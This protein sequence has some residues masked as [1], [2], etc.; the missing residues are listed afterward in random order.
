MLKSL[1]TI[2][3]IN[4]NNL[5][6]EG[7][8]LGALRKELF[9]LNTSKDDLIYKLNNE[10]KII[11]DETLIYLNQFILQMRKDIKMLGDLIILKAEEV[12]VQEDI[13]REMFTE[14][15]KIEILEHK[16]IEDI[17]TL[18]REKDRKELDEISQI[19]WKNNSKPRR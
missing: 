10:A 17:K 9:I 3:K 8:K 5:E 15:K 11:G 12:R 16:K 19:I 1:Q 13:V 14:L 7:Y 2:K 4:K 18:E 6:N